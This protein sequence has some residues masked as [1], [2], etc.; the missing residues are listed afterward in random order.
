MIL[1]GAVGL[2]ILGGGAAWLLR[3]E[4][5]HPTSGGAGGDLPQPSGKGFRLSAAFARRIGLASE[6]AALRSFRPV[7][8]LV[9]TVATDPRRVAVVGS[10]IAARVRRVYK[11]LGD[12]VRKEEVLAD[13][14]SAEL[15]RAQADLLKAK[16]R[17]VAAEAEAQRAAS[18]A[19]ERV[20]SR[21][22]A[23]QAKAQA[24]VARAER[25]AAEQSMR[26]LG[27]D[28]G[29]PLGLLRL[30]SP[31]AGRVIEAKL[32]RGQAVEPSHAAYVVADLSSLWVELK[33]FE[34]DLATVRMGDP[35]EVVPASHGGHAVR[36]VV[37][38]V[39]YV[40]D[41]ATRSATV[42]VEIR[43]PDGQLRPG[44]SVKA[45]LLADGSRVATLAVPRGAVTVV[46]GVPHV[47][48]MAEPDL[49]EPR[50]LTL[51]PH[52]RSYVAVRAGLKAGERVVTGGLF[53][54][55]SEIYR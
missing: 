14:D 54:I 29:T 9:G 49:V 5:P 36:G 26:A 15:A 37:A 39:G 7:V 32:A 28:R 12:P 23:E 27:G 33:V 13:L 21:R 17:E 42:R 46:D 19:A 44:Q 45:E 35:V 34:R 38:H 24:A 50:P 8:Q 2:A 1:L 20:G 48:V 4:E 47:F 31:I 55:K 52:D 22:E 3:S 51:G 6:P 25:E 30:R 41:V 11:V 53:A 18:L 10:R 40:L 16:A 43:N